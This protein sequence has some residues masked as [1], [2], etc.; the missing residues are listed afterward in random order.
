LTLVFGP[1]RT[2]SPPH[3][4]NFMSNGLAG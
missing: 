1:I 3:F 4:H 2:Q